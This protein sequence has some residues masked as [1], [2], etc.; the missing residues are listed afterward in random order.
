MNNQY[1]SYEWA[2]ETFNTFWRKYARATKEM[3]ELLGIS[4]DFII[5]M[6][7]QPK[8]KRVY[9]VWYLYKCIVK[10]AT[11]LKINCKNCNESLLR[12]LTAQFSS[13]YTKRVSLSGGFGLMDESTKQLA[14]K[15]PDEN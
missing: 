15:F 5:R 9:R 6:M 8:D 11:A 13:L 2:K 3:A 7:I 14:F 1:Y 4:Y 12:D 10:E